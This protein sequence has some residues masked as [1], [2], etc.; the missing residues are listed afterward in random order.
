ME[1]VILF[2]LGALAVVLGIAISVGAHE[3]GHLLAAKA[4]G[5][6]VTKYF[7]GFGPTL[8]STKRGETEYGVKAIPLGGFCSIAGMY[9]SPSRGQAVEAAAGTGEAEVAPLPGPVNAQQREGYATRV[10]QDALDMDDNELGPGEEHR[11]FYR[12]AIWKRLTVMLGGIAANF[13]LAIVFFAIALT[14]FGTAQ[15][16]TTLSSV[17]QCVLP[18]T[19]SRQTCESTDT[20]SPGAAAGLQVGD[21]ILSIDGTQITEWSQ[22]TALVQPAAGKTLTFVIERDGVQKTLEVVPTASLRYVTDANGNVKTDASG[23]ALTQTVGFVGIGPSSA[24]VPQ[25]LTSAF[26]TTATYT[27]Q[28]VNAIVTLPQKLVGV[29]QS[30]FSSEQR[31]SDSPVSVVGVGRAAGEIAASSALPASAKWATIF[32]LIGALNVSL[33]VFNLVPLLPL[34]GGHAAGAIWEGVRRRW[35]AIRRKPDPGPFDASTL[36]PL[37]TVV[38]VILIVMGGILIVADVFDPISLFG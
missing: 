36:L 35:A 30:L 9:P 37:T 1:T 25:P 5:I 2:I 7:I 8:W 28:V 11:A 33:A 13:V 24:L 38:T 20:V 27:G 22:V 10:A 21:T 16:T 6:K 31:A 14:G 34:D 15:L 12:A 18:A 29:V 4:F 23:T 3:L 19:S 17:S 32:S 26:S